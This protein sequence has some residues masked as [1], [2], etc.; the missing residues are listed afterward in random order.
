MVSG[1]HGN[2]R[3]R[4]FRT[5]A[6]EHDKG[7]DARRQGTGKTRQQRR[8]AGMPVLR[9][10]PA[11]VPVLRGRPAG[12]PVLRGGQTTK[13]NDQ[14]T[15]LGRESTVPDRSERQQGARQR[16]KDKATKTSKK[17]Q[18]RRP[19]GMPRPT[20]RTTA[21]KG[22]G[23]FKALQETPATTKGTKQKPAAART[24]THFGKSNR[25]AAGHGRPIQPKTAKNAKTGHA[26]IGQTG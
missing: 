23:T 26:Q 12:M 14:L 20:R 17:R 18:Q 3:S 5:V 4:P 10:R 7:R 24:N 8:P 16:M 11:G 22:G 25:A 1:L 19:A 9:G 21:K 6:M 2:D 15:P 13:S